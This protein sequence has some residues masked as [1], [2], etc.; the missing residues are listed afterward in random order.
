MRFNLLL[1]AAGSLALL[2]SCNS[3][4]QKPAVSTSTEKE[5]T[6]T[7]AAF[8]ADTAFAFVKKQAAFGPRVPNSPQHKECA[9]WLETTMRKYTKDV[10]VQSFQMKTYNGITLN[11]KNIIGIFNPDAKDRI[12]L[13]S[14]WDSRPYADNDPDVSKHR[15]PVDGVN[16]GASG[17]GILLEAARQLSIK[18]PAVGVDLI[19]LD[20]ED[21][22]AP[23]DEKN[24]GTE[25]DWALGSQ[26]W[27]KN[28]HKAG[29]TAKFGILLDMVG[30]ENATFRLEASSMYY[31]PDIMNKVWRVA[32]S[33]GYS[34]YFLAENSNGVTDDHVYINEVRKVPTIDI[35]QNDPS[36]ESGFYKYWH[37]VNDNLAGI[38]KQTLRA[39]GE[40]ILTTVYQEK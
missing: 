1:I 30:A 21:Y 25:D 18:A 39:V 24:S 23:Q 7:A 37:T 34:S 33:I 29:Y 13:C 22:G 10:V 11:L 8:N 36:T 17:I 9:K 38:D 40:T 15:T 20:G 32:A 27:S 14:H 5:I 6:V 26:Y 28:P 4:K 3:S 31:A 12:L 16:D 35:I 2:I 19:L